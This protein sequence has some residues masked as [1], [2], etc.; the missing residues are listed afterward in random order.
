[1]IGARPGARLRR[2]PNLARQSAAHRFCRPLHTAIE[3]R[4][5]GPAGRSGW[6][7]EPSGGVAN[8]FAA[9]ERCDVVRC[10]V[11]GSATVRGG[12]SVVGDTAVFDAVSMSVAM[13]HDVAWPEVVCGGVAEAAQVHSAGRADNSVSRLVGV[14][15]DDDVSFPS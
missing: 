10:G 8:L 2:S 1:M 3:S 11:T 4:L 13:K 6:C 9:L 7:A 15:G 14:S 12:V 5:V